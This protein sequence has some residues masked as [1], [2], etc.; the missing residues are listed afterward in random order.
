MNHCSHSQCCSNDSPEP[1]NAGVDA[2]A[3][4]PNAEALPVGA[5]ALGCAP[6]VLVDIAP[7]P[8]EANAGVCP[9]KAGVDPVLV[10]KPKFW[11]GAAAVLGPKAGVLAAKAG[12]LPPNAGVLEGTAAV[13]LAPKAKGAAVG[14]LLGAAAPEAKLGA[15]PGP[16][17]AL[18]GPKAKAGVVLGA[19]AEAGEG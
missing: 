15:L 12:A 2:G 17:A 7:K 13:L 1:P 5:P 4:C 14:V 9:P 19:S 3:V 6:K 11:A 18:L 10:P 8:D 16:D